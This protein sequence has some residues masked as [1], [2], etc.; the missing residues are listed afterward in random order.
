MYNIGRV[1]HLYLRKFFAQIFIRTTRNERKLSTL[2][3]FLQLPFDGRHVIKSVK[4]SIPSLTEYEMSHG[5]KLGIDTH[6]DSSCAGKHVRILEFISGKSFSVKPFLDTYEPRND[7]SLINGVVAVDTD[8]GNGYILELN[9]FLD[10]TKSMNDSIL[11]PLQARLNGIIIDDIPKD[12]CHYGVSTQ[13]IFLPQSDF[14]VPIE[15]NGPIPFV[16]IRYP[17]DDDLDNYKWIELT[18]PSEWNPYPD[19]SISSISSSVPYNTYD[20]NIQAR[21]YD[22]LTQSITISSVDSRPKKNTLSPEKLSNLWKIP[23]HNAKRTLNATTNNYIRTNEGKLSRRYRT[24]LFQKRY[25]RMG[26]W[27]S[28]FYTDTLF[29][30]TKTL[31]QFTCAQLYGNRAI[32]KVYLMT[33][34]SDAHESLS[35]F[36]HEIG[37][38]SEIHSDGT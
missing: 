17:T 8:D 10:F 20:N 19:S 5:C 25:R 26:G 16:H 1:C 12:L 18:S 7:V 6:A 15:F 23:L 13:S 34:K 21:F 9:N 3:S 27:Y 29:F 22:Q 38:P 24:D 32:C 35:S 31:D 36:V 33:S 30:K 14:T 11:V 4:K 28:R 2:R 37:I